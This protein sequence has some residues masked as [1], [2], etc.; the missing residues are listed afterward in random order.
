M[1]TVESQI[2]FSV[3]FLAQRRNVIGKS[4]LVE[5]LEKIGV[6]QPYRVLKTNFKLFDMEI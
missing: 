3:G 4:S 6:W 5:L 2:V 1:Y